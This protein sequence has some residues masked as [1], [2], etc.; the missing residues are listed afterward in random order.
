MKKNID[1]LD[2]DPII[3]DQQW[4]CLSF[5]SPF[6]NQ[7]SDIHAL[8]FR[9]AF[10]K[11]EEAKERCKML[12]ES[13]PDF[14][15]YIAQGFRWLPW[16]PDPSKIKTEEYANEQLNEL[17]KGTKENNIKAKSHFKQRVREQ[18]EKALEESLNY[19]ESKREFPLV[20]KKRHSDLTEEIRSLKEKLEEAET[21]LQET[22][23]LLNN[24]SLEEMEHAEFMH[25]DHQEKLKNASNPVDA[26]KLEKEF[27]EIL[28][29]YSNDDNPDLTLLYPRTNLSSSTV[30]DTNSSLF[31]KTDRYETDDPNQ[32]ENPTLNEI[33]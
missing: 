17:V 28:H 14:D 9:G 6:S 19:S 20:V 23:I 7:K 12:R 15:I 11:E 24:I 25:L 30:S 13:D 26:N 32:T 27:R 33:A 3:Q 10:E 5:V 16:Y 18:N 31:N 4:V 29:K 1:F 22:S 2:E 8:K 21:K